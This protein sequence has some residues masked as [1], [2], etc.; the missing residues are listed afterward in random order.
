VE[1]ETYNDHRLAMA[2][3]LVGLRRGNVWIRNPGCVGKTYPGFW[4][5]I[6]RF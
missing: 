2:L 3:A 5:E 6:G 4:E 1:F